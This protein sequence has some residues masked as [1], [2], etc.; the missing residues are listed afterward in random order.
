M[1][2]LLGM[3]GVDF[4]LTS[5][6]GDREQ[7]KRAGC[8]GIQHL[9]GF[10]ELR[11]VTGADKTLLGLVPGDAAAQVGAALMDSQEAAILQP[12]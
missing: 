8:R 1:L 4:H 5:L 12:C 7:V 10:I 11:V 2:T 3:A 9:P 6:D